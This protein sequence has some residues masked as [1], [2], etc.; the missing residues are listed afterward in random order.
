MSNQAFDSFIDSLP[1][2]LRNIP[3]VFHAPYGFKVIELG[4]KKR[5]MPGTFED[6]QEAEAS[7]LNVD[8]ATIKPK[9]TRGCGNSSPTTCAGNCGPG[10][11]GTCGGNSYVPGGYV[12]CHCVL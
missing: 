1:D 4:G 11:T 9:D 10:P 6:Y 3:E 2:E 8:P 5:W 7:R 12:Y